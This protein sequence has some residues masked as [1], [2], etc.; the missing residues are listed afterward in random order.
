MKPLLLDPLHLNP[1]L[2]AAADKAAGLT[3]RDVFACP[4]FWALV[5]GALGL[6]F[7]LPSR[8]RYGNAIGSLLLA[9][10]AGLFAVDLPLLGPWLDQGVFWL[11]AGVTLAAS[12]CTI[13]SRSP[14]YCA[15]WFALSLLGTA[16]L[17]LFQGAQFLGVATIVVYAGAIVVTFLFV[18][19]L[20]QP[21][22]HTMY[23]RISWGWL[24]KV[25]GVITAGALVGI[26]TFMLGGL[27]DA[28]TAA[29]TKAHDLKADTSVLSDHHMA[30][31][32]RHLFA[33]HLIS[34]EIAG[35]LLLA[36]LVGAIAIAAFGK[37]ASGGRQPSERLVTR[38]EEAFR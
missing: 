4:T 7:V 29:A 37:R 28:T 3:A 36:A 11:L 5:S 2:L 1:L 35:T 20:A 25:F 8:V 21:E 26:L 33:E 31:I 30:N 10:A 34:V 9:I 38:I 14:V 16:G 27:K 23:D 6:W 15:I 12:V 13:S 32:G 19:M 17:Y 22:G 24:P 18:I